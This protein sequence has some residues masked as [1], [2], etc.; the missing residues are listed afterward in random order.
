MSKTSATE[1][2]QKRHRRVRSKVF[3]TGLRPRLSVFK[4][5]TAIYV[6]IIDDEKS[7]TLVSAS[8]I[9]TKGKSMMEKA[10]LVGSAI[11]KEAKAKGIEKVVFDRGG[12]VYTGRIE[13][14]ADSARAGGL[15]F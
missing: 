9:G 3:G 1:K 6:Q 2:R 5:N 10:K 7:V 11:A 8:S 13:A 14:L 4:S 15:I 12:Y